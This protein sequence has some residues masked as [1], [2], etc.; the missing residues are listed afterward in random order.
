MLWFLIFDRIIFFVKG[1]KAKILIT[2]ANGY[3]GSNLAYRL[4]SN[5][6]DVRLTD[7]SDHCMLEG[8]DYRPCDFLVPEQIE[9]VIAEVDIIYF[10]TGRT[11]N[12]MEGYDRAADFVLGNEVTLLNLLNVIRTLEKKPKVVF[13]STRL[14]YHGGIEHP[15]NE[16][17]TLNPKSIYAVNKWAC[18]AYLQL[19]AENFGID[20]TIF[21]ISLPYGSNVP[22]EN[23]SYGAMAFL[24][25]RARNGEPLKLFGEGSQ[26]VSLVHIDDLSQI[27]IQGG[28]HPSTNGRIFNVGGPDAMTMR[29]VL[30][31]I[32]KT[33]DVDLLNEDWPEIIRNA[34]QGSLIISSDEILNLLGYTFETNFLA[35]LNRTDR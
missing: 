7:L 28:I 15:I 9:K 6:A 30:E 5:G 12:S 13:P 14:I 2:G 1:S 17:G 19:Y 24:L 32:C 3:L 22:M 23:I 29:E 21:R 31:A 27:L 4:I 11:G 20:Y 26:Y 10:F 18:E 16:K 25:N 8:V 35:W 33:F 34:D